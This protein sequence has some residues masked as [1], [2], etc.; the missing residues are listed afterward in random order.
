ME[1]VW[2]SLPEKTGRTFWLSREER[3]KNKEIA[4]REG[5][6]EKTVEYR[7]RVALRHF[8]KLFQSIL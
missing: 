7:I 4:L 2:K 6:S 1:K 5:V 8:R 3:L